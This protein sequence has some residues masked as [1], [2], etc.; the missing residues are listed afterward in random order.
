MDKAIAY[1][2]ASNDVAYYFAERMKTSFEKYHPD[3]ECKIITNYDGKELFGTIEQPRI[4][5]VWAALSVKMIRHYLETYKTVIK[6]DA[7]VVITH[8]LDE[9]LDKEFDVACSLNVAG[10]SQIWDKDYCNLGVTAIRNKQ[11]AEEWEKL[12]YD[13]KFIEDNSFLNLEQ[14]VMNYLT[15]SGKYNV[16]IVDKEDSY[17]NETSREFWKDMRVVS[18]TKGEKLFIENRIV[19]ALHWAGG[20]SLSNKYSHPD[21]SPEVREFL[22]KITNTRDFT[23][24]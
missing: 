8:R 7:D 17:Y 19:K 23:N 9:F 16:L 5:S 10:Y 12:T 18:T 11:F 3:I 2:M 24:G 4:G 1:V 20:G 15:H 22:N 13:S 21:F 14:D 6:L